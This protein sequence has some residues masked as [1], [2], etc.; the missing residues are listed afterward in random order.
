M[1]DSPSTFAILRMNIVSH[2]SQPAVDG[3]DHIGDAR[4]RLRYLPALAANGLQS[5]CDNI[6]RSQ[7]SSENRCTANRVAH[8]SLLIEV[9]G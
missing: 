1:L 9:E 3:A 8:G 7:D 4:L 5:M 6:S 2:G